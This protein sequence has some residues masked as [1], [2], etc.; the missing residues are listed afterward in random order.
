MAIGEHIRCRLRNDAPIASSIEQRRIV[1]RT[2]LEIGRPFDLLSFGLAD[3]HLHTETASQGG[4]AEYARRVEGA[5][6]K[7]LGFELGFERVRVDPVA[8][9]WHLYRLFTYVLSQS[10]RHGV[11]HLDPLLEGTNLPDLLGLRITGSYTAANVRRVLPRIQRGQL[12]EILDLKSLAP[13]DGPIE[14]IPSAAAAVICCRSLGGCGRSVI[15]ARRAAIEVVG[16]RLELRALA[17]LLGIHPSN[18]HRQRAR[19]SDPALVE[20]VR[21]QLGLRREKW[22]LAMGPSAA[23]KER[24]R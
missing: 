1:A 11:S 18:V 22:R 9:L 6:T 21:L 23:E 17:D 20:M 24:D 7:K 15:A 8:D 3:T 12:L 13:A 5:L 2:V 4:G 10:K 19:P 14:E 16:D